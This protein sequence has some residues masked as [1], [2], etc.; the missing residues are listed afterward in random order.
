MDQAVSLCGR[1]QDQRPLTE[2]GTETRTTPQGVAIYKVVPNMSTRH[3]RT[4][5]PT[6]SEQSSELRSCVKEEVDVLGS[7]SLIVCTVFLDVSNTE[8]EEE[9]EEEQEEQEEQEEHS[10]DS[11]LQPRPVCSSD[12]L[13][14][15]VHSGVF[16]F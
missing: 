13:K 16:F 4:L 12:W 7:P 5:S 6:S 14:G 11:L 8:E 1:R 3:P 2:T 9:E 15:A 10:R